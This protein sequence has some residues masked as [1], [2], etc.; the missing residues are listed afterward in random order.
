MRIVSNG[1]QPYIV[2]T[3]V[4]TDGETQEEVTTFRMKLDV[5]EWHVL[6]SRLVGHFRQFLRFALD[7]CAISS[8]HMDTERVLSDFYPTGGQQPVDM[9][10]VIAAADIRCLQGRKLEE[11]SAFLLSSEAAPIAMLEVFSVFTS[12]IQL[13]VAGFGYCA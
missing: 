11:A 10:K 2:Q 6:G 3:G 8:E 5:S 12:V 9:L 13:H 7:L 1:V 4:D